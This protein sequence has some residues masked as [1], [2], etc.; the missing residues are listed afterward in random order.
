SENHN[1]GLDEFQDG[2]V[3]G[4]MFGVLVIQDK[5]GKLG[6]LSAFSG[7]LADSNDHKR[8]VPPV[9]DMLQENSF[10]LQEETILNSI[11]REIENL[12]TTAYY[13][14]NNSDVER[15]TKESVQ[16]I[17]ELKN[18]MK[19]KNSAGKVIPVA[20]DTTISDV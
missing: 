3:I 8:F 15:L 19:A 13:I 2:L 7:K 1:F 18:W 9:F 5:D 12:R 10:F 20:N 11:N 16:E 14:Q 4:K 6:Y 17:A